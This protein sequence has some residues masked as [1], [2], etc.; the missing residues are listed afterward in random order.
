MARPTRAEVDRGL[1]RLLAG[2]VVVL[3]GAVGEELEAVTVERRPAPPSG[4]RRC[5]CGEQLR[6]YPGTLCEDCAVKS[7]VVLGLLGKQP[8]VEVGRR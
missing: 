7:W 3:G 2:Q 1:R 6:S 5:H 8:S 4:E